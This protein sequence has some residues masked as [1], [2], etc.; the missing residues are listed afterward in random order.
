MIDKPKNMR[1]KK[2]IKSYISTFYDKISD[3]ENEDM[4]NVI[5]EK[6]NTDKD[7]NKRVEKIAKKLQSSTSTKSKKGGRRKTRRKQKGGV[8]DFALVAAAALIAFGCYQIGQA[9]RYYADREMGNERYIQAAIENYRRPESSDSGSGSDSHG[10]TPPRASRAWH[11][12]G[13]GHNARS[14]FHSP[15]VRQRGTPGRRLS[16]IHAALTNHDNSLYN[17]LDLEDEGKKTDDLGPRI[18]IERRRAA[19]APPTFRVDEVPASSSSG[20]DEDYDPLRDAQ[21]ELLAVAAEARRRDAEKKEK[22]EG[23]KRKTLRK[24]KKHRKKITIK[25]K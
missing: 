22:M 6:Y 9:I 15:N 20:S 24:R 19:T 23:G 25:R 14:A 11:A 17:D 4:A 8:G 12:L 10:N 7:F 5:L 1:I 13:R 2:E 3:K 16:N 21:G 18:N